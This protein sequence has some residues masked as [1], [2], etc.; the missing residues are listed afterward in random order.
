MNYREQ[1]A[2][3]ASNFWSHRWQALG[4]LALLALL[5]LFASLLR[6][7]TPIVE[8]ITTEEAPQT[9]A[10]QTSKLPATISRRPPS[11]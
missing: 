7:Q 8:T 10:T 3:Q 5:F 1:F 11:T 9:H 2:E 6:R 4:T